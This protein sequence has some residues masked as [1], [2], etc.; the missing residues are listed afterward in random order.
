MDPVADSFDA[1]VDAPVEGVSTILFRTLI[2]GFYGSLQGD[3][4]GPPPNGI[5]LHNAHHDFP[6]AHQRFR[7]LNEIRG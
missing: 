6:F 5:N 4:E 7:G 3:F 1:F 2:G